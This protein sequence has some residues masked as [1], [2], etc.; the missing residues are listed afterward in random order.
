MQ[1]MQKKTI[2]IESETLNKDITINSYGHFGV[3]LL[4]FSSCSNDGCE[5]ER[6]GIL[7]SISTPINNG[8]IKV[9]CVPNLIDESW[10]DSEKT[11]I[12]KSKHHFNY[13]RFIEEELLPYIY[14]ECSG[15]VP[16]ITF[17]VDTGAFFAANAFFR[18]PDLFIGTMAFSGNYDIGHFT[19]GY[20]DDNCYYNSP[21]HYLSNLTENY[22]ISLLLSRKHIYI[23]SGSGE[24]ENPGHSSHLS[25]ILTSKGI[26]HELEIWG[27]EWGH[28]WTTWNAMIKHFLRKL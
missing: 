11:P 19:R 9:F 2:V 10:N 28:D 8:K 22:W 15:A 1:I 16:I 18:R 27:N 23:S 20:F 25:D 6:N 12:E 7:N 26:R 21:I 14:N 4:F 3:P 17:G 13:N 24:N 5:Y